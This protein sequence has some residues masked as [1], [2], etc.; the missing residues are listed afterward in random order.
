MVAYQGNLYAVEPNHGELDRITPDGQVSRVIDISASQGHSVPVSVD[1]FDGHF[2][3]GNLTTVP[4]VAGAAKVLK[5]NPNGEIASE[6]TGFTNIVGVAFDKDG[7]LFVLEGTV[8]H[9][10]YTPDFGDI[11]RVKPD[12]TRDTVATGLSFPTALTVGPDGALYVSNKGFGFPP[13]TGEIVR[14][15]LDP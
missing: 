4:V 7:N 8:G 9:P 12:G 1:V 13:G 3:V 14:V 6:W 10:E 11:V 2:F 5:V 15:E